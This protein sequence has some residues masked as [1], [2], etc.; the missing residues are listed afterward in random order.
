MKNV[1]VNSHQPTVISVIVYCLLSIV[2]CFSQSTKIDSLQKVVLTAKDDTNKVNTLL[3]LAG[4]YQGLSLDSTILYGDKAIALAKYVSVPTQKRGWDIGIVKASITVAVAYYRKS[5]YA[6]SLE[7]YYKAL[8]IV[9]KM[10]EDAKKKDDKNSVSSYV[11]IYKSKT[12]GN[13]GLVYWN[14][15][16]YARALKYYFMALKI[17]EDLG[18]KNGIARHLGNIGVVYAEEATS[19]SRRMDKDDL[20]ENA[21]H[22]FL[23]ANSIFEE[24]GNK[25][26]VAT[27][28][29]NIGNT[30]VSIED[31]PK[32]MEYYLKALKMRQ[33]IGAKD[34]ISSAYG[35]LGVVYYKTHKYPEAE[36]YLKKAIALS[37]SIGDIDGI[38]EWEQT[39]SRLDSARGNFK[40]ALQ[41]YKQYIAARDSITNDEN[42]KKQTQTE[43]Q[44]E[45]DKK[46]SQEKAE[47]EKKDAVAGA[48]KKKQQVVLYS[49]IGGLA[50]VLLFALL[51][52][53]SLI[54]IRNKNKEINMQKH[55]I[56]EK[57]K[58]IL[59]S[60]RYAR[61]IQT[62]LLPT[63]KY[64]D[65]ILGRLMKN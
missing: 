17:D 51:I 2:Y 44:Y 10:E 64:I 54:Q 55:V 43:M 65:K 59:D 57:Q 1:A 47:Q 49:V 29:G 31:Y 7:Y 48:E 38:K 33:E 39:F 42:T 41:H 40:G 52:F 32:A 3:K 56:E 26:A 53:R 18:N 25:R 60:I 13:I 62:A 5:N 46:T 35:N 11:L 15:A 28:L 50:I 21:L 30:Y 12:M 19:F 20:V 37:D 8:S 6:K 34:L 61:R 22:Y 23:R 9:D 58:E 63:E 36:I 27:V 24:L 14:Q 45:F 4:E 16:D